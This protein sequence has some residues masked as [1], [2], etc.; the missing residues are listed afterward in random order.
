M[1]C[2][3][4]EC[5]PLCFCAGYTEAERQMYALESMTPMAALALGYVNPFP[6]E[7]KAWAGFE[8]GFYDFT[9]K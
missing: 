2:R 5:G 9:Q 8:E 7:S 4:G 1:A 3:G 6:H